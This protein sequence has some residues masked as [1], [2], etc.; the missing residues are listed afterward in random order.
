MEWCER[1]SNGL[2]GTHKLPCKLLLTI[3][4]SYISKHQILHRWSHSRLSAFILTTSLAE[5]SRKS[6]V[7]VSVTVKFNF[8]GEINEKAWM[9]RDLVDLFAAC[10]V[11]LSLVFCAGCMPVFIFPL[12]TWFA[13]M[14]VWI[15]WQHCICFLFVIFLSCHVA[16]RLHFSGASL[17]PLPFFV[18]QGFGCSSFGDDEGLHVQIDLQGFDPQDGITS[19]NFRI[20]SYAGLLPNCT[21]MGPDYGQGLRWVVHVLHRHAVKLVR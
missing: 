6:A 1:S 3:R 10:T 13:V 15:R 5:F 4:S 9:I 18:T 20:K 11:S 17:A 16:P 19:H 7:L 21:G 14:C 12:A 2:L 8:C